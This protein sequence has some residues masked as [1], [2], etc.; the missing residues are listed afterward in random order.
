[1]ISFLKTLTWIIF[2]LP[3]VTIGLVAGFAVRSFVAGWIMGG[4]FYQ[5]GKSFKQAADDLRKEMGGV[6]P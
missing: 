5:P 6:K 1:M 4:L 2:A 3:C